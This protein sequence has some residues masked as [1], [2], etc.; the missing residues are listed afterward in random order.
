[1]G[2]LPKERIVH[3]ETLW[4]GPNVVPATALMVDSKVVMASW[5]SSSFVAMPESVQDEEIVNVAT[6]V[7]RP[8]T[9]GSREGW[10]L[11]LIENGFIVGC[12]VGRDVVGCA[13]NER[14]KSF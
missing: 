8:D 14:R 10:P 13:M 6:H 5:S 3:L 4:F 12:S 9:E 11:G 1:M 7:G 2:P